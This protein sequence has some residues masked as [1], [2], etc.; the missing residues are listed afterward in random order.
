MPNYLHR[1]TKQYQQSISPIDL[2]EPESNYVK[3]PDLLAVAGFNSQ[4]WVIT[5]DVVT[6]MSTS[7]RDAVDTLARD[8]ARDNNVNQLDGLEDLLRA[9]ALVVLDE[10]NLLRA[11]HS[12][13]PR[14]IGNLKTAIR[15]K[16]GT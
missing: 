4:Y 5:D 12:R 2:L 15:N 3:D 11:E 13:A 14:S 16:L 6:L 9:F 10:F 8:A 7:E 1:T